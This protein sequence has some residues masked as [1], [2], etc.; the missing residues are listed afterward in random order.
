MDRVQKI[1]IAKDENVDLVPRRN[2]VKVLPLHRKLSKP[3]L[4]NDMNQSCS[5]VQ[6][7]FKGRIILVELPFEEKCKFILT[8]TWLILGLPHIQSCIT[9]RLNAS[10]SSLFSYLKFFSLAGFMF[11]YARAMD[12]IFLV[13]M[14]LAKRTI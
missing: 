2:F 8:S 10:V 6:L 9:S 11:K 13:S 14:A 7:D 4:L 5:D 1:L 3:L 12:S